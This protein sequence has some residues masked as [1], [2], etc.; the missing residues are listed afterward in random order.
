MTS[1]EPVVYAFSVGISMTAK[2]LAQVDVKVY[3]NNLEAA[4]VQAV[5]Q[6]E[7]TIADL[8]TKGMAIA[9]GGKAD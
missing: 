2:G 3:S 6:Y 7:Q 5:Q 4:R 9:S 1:P 8:K